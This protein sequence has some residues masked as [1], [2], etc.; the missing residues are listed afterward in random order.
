VRQEA[1]QLLGNLVSLSGE[2]S[3]QGEDLILHV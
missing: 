2:L 1:A 3:N